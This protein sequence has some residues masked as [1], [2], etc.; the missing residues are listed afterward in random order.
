MEES[1]YQIIDNTYLALPRKKDVKGTISSYDY[2]GAVERF[3]AVGQVF[4]LTVGSKAQAWRKIMESKL[5]RH[6]QQIGRK[7]AQDV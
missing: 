7:K 4:L 2:D 6:S 5:R 3:R 1:L